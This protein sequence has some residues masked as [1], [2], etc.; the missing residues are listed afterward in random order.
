MDI[1]LSIGVT[2][3]AVTYVGEP[4]YQSSVVGGGHGRG[5]DHIA[6]AEEIHSTEENTQCTKYIFNSVVVSTSAIYLLVFWHY[7]RVWSRGH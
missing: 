1:V 4:Q 5:K 6:G 7:S 3:R 2:K